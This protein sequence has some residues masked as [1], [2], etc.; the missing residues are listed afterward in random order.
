MK[1]KIINNKFYKYI[2]SNWQQV[3]LILLSL[4][5]IWPLLKNG[6]FSHQ[7]DLQV[8]RIVEMKKCVR[9]FQIPCRWVPDMGWG[10]GYPLFNYYGVFSYYLGGIISFVFNYLVTAKILF[11][12]ALT[13][14]GFGMYH[15]V[16]S[17]TN[18]KLSAFVSA[19]LYLFAPYKALDVYVRGALG[20]T[21]ALSL[22]PFVFY[23][24]HRLVEDKNKKKYFILF[25]LSF[26]FFLITHNIMTLVFLPV[27]AVFALYLLF[28]NR[29]KDF[30]VF[31]FGFLFSFLLSSFFLLP[32]FI[33]KDLVQT[34]SLTRFE[35]DFRANFVNINNLFFDRS[36][37]YG[38]SIPGP[39]GKMS[40]QIGIVH[41]LA[42]ILTFVYLLYLLLRKRLSIFNNDSI[43]IT[44]I[45]MLFGLSVFM[46]HNKSAFI[47]ESIKIL[48]YFQF[49][50]RFLSLSIFSASILGGL[51]V[52]KIN[53]KH[54]KMFVLVVTLL[55]VLLNFSYFRPREFYNITNSQKTSSELWENQQKGALLDY[56]PKTAL[57]PREK[58]KD[59][60][61]IV[62]GKAQIENYFTRT[63]SFEFNIVVLE[64]SK[65]EMPIFYFPNWKVYANNKEIEVK[66]DN[67]LGRIEFSLEKGEYD[68]DG[69][70]ENTPIRTI[71]NYLTILGL[72][73]LVVFV[74]LNYKNND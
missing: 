21:M 27:V 26:F 5:L 72:I 25:V 24:L 23:F 20:E 9:D 62:S 53:L 22:I 56:L 18:N 61:N 43:L 6:Y 68:I 48:E 47:W 66:H 2:T 51:F 74:K 45:F 16:K 52:S 60:P 54:Q 59:F 31:F 11:G 17:L 35:L 15:F 1:E 64:K 28:K 29:F 38:T 33:E 40:F 67:I 55:V 8:I 37:G 42:S 50:W 70:F 63:D 71:S 69:R 30:K 44:S 4:L 34:E 13:L 46:I 73:G 36:W 39:E 3:F 41:W 57:E 65:I 58:A 32:A 10:N 12:I 49:P 19:T 7:D 14:G